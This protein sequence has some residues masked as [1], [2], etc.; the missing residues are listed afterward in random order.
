MEGKG[1]GVGAYAEVG[2]AGQDEGFV[3]CPEGEGSC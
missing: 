2:R 3:L 1:K